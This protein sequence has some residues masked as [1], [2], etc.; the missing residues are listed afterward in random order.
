MRP[1]LLQEITREQLEDALATVPDFPE[2]L[3]LTLNLLMLAVPRDAA[4][5][6]AFR[7]LRAP[8]DLFTSAP[9]PRV[10]LQL[11]LAVDPAAPP[12]QAEAAINT[13]AAA[14]LRCFPSPA[15]AARPGPGRLEIDLC[16]PARPMTQEEE[17]RLASFDLLPGESTP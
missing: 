8:L 16:S 11:S 13:A 6:W 1:P 2:Q 5:T 10:N 4:S 7:P 12:D 3:R 14:L 9:A 17:R 15:R